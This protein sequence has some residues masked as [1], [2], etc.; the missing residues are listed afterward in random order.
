VELQTDRLVLRELTPEHAADG[1]RLYSDPRVAKYLGGTPPI[2]IEDEARRFAGH[3]ERYWET[4]GY[5][6]M[7]VFQKS[8]DA[9]VGICGHLHWEIDGVHE[10][11]V[12][13][14]LLPEYWGKGYA[15]EAARALAQD[16]FDR[17]GCERVISLVMPQNAA[18]A[19]VAMKN[20]MHLDREWTLN[21]KAVSLYA[22]S[23][24]L[25]PNA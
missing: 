12:A 23:R 25:S 18:S 9:F 16:A 14:A 15:T 4:R 24:E 19:N 7:A 10:V 6:L 11:E 21:G 5:G 13:Y 1:F 3:H 17:L 2:S 8:D 22:R 20:G